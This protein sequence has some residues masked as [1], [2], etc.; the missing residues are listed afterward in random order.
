MGVSLVDV[1]WEECV[2]DNI[3]YGEKWEDCPDAFVTTEN[4]QARN[5]LAQ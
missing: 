1:A 3:T 5:P 2:D 4:Q